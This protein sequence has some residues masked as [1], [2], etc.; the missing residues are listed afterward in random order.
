M[1]IYGAN[2]LLIFFLIYVDDIVI[3]S[4][5]ASAITQFIRDLQNDF[6]IKD[7]GSLHFFLGVEA[8]WDNDG[9]HLSQQRYI[10]DLLKCTNM[11]LAKPISSPMSSS[12]LPSKFTGNTVFDPTLFCNTVG[13]L[14]YLSLTPT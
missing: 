5:N 6:A 13:S 3:T 10:C 2:G 1:F 9:L 14:Q 8:T 4:S 12:S 11:S 7:M